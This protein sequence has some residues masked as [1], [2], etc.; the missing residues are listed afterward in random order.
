MRGQ[1]MENIIELKVLI[2]CP[3]CAGKIEK[4]LNDNDRIRSA[5]L[6]FENQ[7]L[8][9]NTDLNA[10]EIKMLALDASDEISFPDPICTCCCHEEG[11]RE[12]GENPKTT[13]TLEFHPVIDCPVCAGKVNDALNER[14]D[15]EKAEY[16][17]AAGRLRVRTSLS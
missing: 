9:V 14:D 7:T 13:P 8:K 15:I 1:S 5:V 2:E 12:H 4:A 11:C 6:D 16:N 10:E 3:H 17:F